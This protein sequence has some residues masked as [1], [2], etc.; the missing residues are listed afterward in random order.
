M[1]SSPNDARTACVPC[2]SSQYYDHDLGKCSKCPSNMEPRRSTEGGQGGCMCVKG[3]YNATTSNFACVGVGRNYDRHAFED[4]ERTRDE[5]GVCR[6]VRP[7]LGAQSASCVD[8]AG[9]KVS[10]RAGF[11][12]SMRGLSLLR[13]APMAQHDGA[14][15]PERRRQLAERPLLRMAVFP[16]PLPEA[17]QNGTCAVGYSGPLCSQCAA[18]FGRAGLSGTCHACRGGQD[19][20][21]AVA[22]LLLTLGAFGAVTF[23]FL[24]GEKAVEEADLAAKGEAAEQASFFALML[25]ML[26]SVSFQA[27]MKTL[28]SNIQILSDFECA[29]GRS[30]AS[31]SHRPPHSR[32]PDT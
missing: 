4:T 26:S 28:V 13:F 22:M 11:G 5:G 7:P 12:L 29:V 23:L 30:F 25:G 20:V 3:R 24:R 31:S 32:S 6:T 17:C 21:V 2:Q 1:R 14:M 16:C 10:L 27:S 19:T 18:R 9:G 15:A 8:V